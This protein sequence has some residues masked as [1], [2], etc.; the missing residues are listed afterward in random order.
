M[1]ITHR[2]EVLKGDVRDPLDRRYKLHRKGDVL[3]STDIEFCCDKMEETWEER[4]PPIGLGE[5]PWAGVA[6][7]TYYEG[8]VEESRPITF[9]PFCAEIIDVVQSGEE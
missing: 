5:G 4:S 3:R 7:L 1:K 9:C 8:D 2:A 6:I